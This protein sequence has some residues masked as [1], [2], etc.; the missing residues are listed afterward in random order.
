[1]KDEMILRIL[2]QE[3]LDLELWLKRYEILKFEGYFCEDKKKKPWTTSGLGPRWT[4]LVRPRARWCTHQGSASD[5]S[6]SPVLGGDSRGGGVRH[7]G[8]SPGLTEA[9]EAVQQLHDGGEGGG[10]GALHEGSLG[11]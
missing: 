6:G 3:S 4:M 10:G 11:A 5:R 1:M 9:Q 7:R 8:L 2:V